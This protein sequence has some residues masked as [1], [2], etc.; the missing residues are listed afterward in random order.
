M[1]FSLEQLMKSGNYNKICDTFFSLARNKET[2]YKLQKILYNGKIDNYSLKSQFQ[3]RNNP[4]IEISRRISLSSVL[5]TNPETFNFLVENNINIF[6]GTNANALPN[7]LKYGINSYATLE[8]KGIPILTGERS[9]QLY[10]KRNFI[11]FTDVL[12]IAEGYS[13]LSTN[14]NSQLSFSIVIGINETNL[15][16]REII[17]IHSDISEIGVMNHFPLK[18]ISCICVPED[19]ISFVKQ[20]IN[21]NQIAVLGL[22]DLSKK[23]YYIDDCGAI[24]IKPEVYKK[25][26]DN[27]PKFTTHEIQEM[28]SK[29]LL[30]EI[31]KFIY[32]VQNYFIQKEE[33]DNEKSF[34]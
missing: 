17:S 5:L 32:K 18:Y 11:S 7:I 1:S 31:R 20:I 4:M 8:E 13:T 6:H 26:A 3:C 19:K 25:E 28:A 15:A 2:Q 14:K 29:R 9:T 33:K 34:R 23:A 27:N 12:D 22:R 30:S 24:K 16:R 21:N 10:Q